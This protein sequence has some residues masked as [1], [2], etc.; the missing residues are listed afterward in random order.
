MSDSAGRVAD[1]TGNWVDTSAPVWLRPYL[2]LT[3]LDRIE[4][5]A[6]QL[7]CMVAERRDTVPRRVVEDRTLVQ[8]STT[9]LV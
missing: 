5:L 4:R 2:R 3:R 1:A 6:D 7:P 9:L 8:L